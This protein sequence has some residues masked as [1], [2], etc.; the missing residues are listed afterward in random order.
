M[1]A[2][3]RTNRRLS[4]RFQEIRDAFQDKF[5]KPFDIRFTPAKESLAELNDALRRKIGDIGEKRAKGS[6]LEFG[7]VGFDVEELRKRALSGQQLT[8]EGLGIKET[9][10]AMLAGN[11]IVQDAGEAIPSVLLAEIEAAANE[12]LLKF[13]EKVLSIEAQM[14]AGLKQR[15]RDQSRVNEGMETTNKHARREL[16]FL[17]DG[18]RLHINK[19]AKINEEYYYKKLNL[20][21]DLRGLGY[22]DEEINKQIDLLEAER[23]KAVEAER[24]AKAKKD[25]LYLE[26]ELDKLRSTQFQMNMADKEYGLLKN[27]NDEY[28]RRKMLRQEERYLL[29]EMKKI[30]W[31][32]QGLQG[33]KLRQAQ[34]I[35]EAQLDTEDS[36]RRQQLLLDAATRTERTR[37]DLEARSTQYQSEKMK[38]WIG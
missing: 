17:K 33:E 12:E 19:I 35:F 5:N 32:T 34:Q 13:Q 1:N 2:T 4:A 6:Q 9:I 20:K 31:E 38:L 24:I 18:L 14:E 27:Y 15:L 16:A 7:G 11:K 37:L 26:S 28:D 30:E 8:A 22:L 10:A 3:E 23:Q 36:L 21:E 25:L 29:L